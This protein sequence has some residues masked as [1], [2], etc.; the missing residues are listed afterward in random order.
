MPGRPRLIDV[1]RLVALAAADAGTRRLIALAGAPGSGKST[2]ADTVV[3]RLDA[4]RPGAA[5][6]LAMDG[7]HFD[8]GVLV[9]RALLAR[10]GAPETFDVGGFRHMLQRLKANE[11]DEIAVPVFDRGLDISRAS[12]RLLSRDVRVV[13]VEGN[14]LLLTSPPW[15]GLHA[16]FDIT[17]MLRV[18]EA[19]LRQR[20][21][22]RWRGYGLSPEQIERKIEHNDLPS[23]RRLRE[24]HVVARHHRDIR[25]GA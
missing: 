9:G 10:K 22:A 7:Y 4:A 25:G 16:S 19:V 6:V 12:A 5:A 24:L 17:V 3:A 15:A 2:V 18:D 23:G 20:L 13:V 1:D 8:D 14:Y 11:E 21:A